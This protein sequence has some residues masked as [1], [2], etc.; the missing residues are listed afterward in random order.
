[1]VLIQASPACKTKG[2]V[3]RYL[4]PFSA[5]LLKTLS[6]PPDFSL[7]P[8]GR[9]TI[10]H[11]YP[12]NRIFEKSREM[13]IF[14]MKKIISLS[15]MLLICFLSFAKNNSNLLLDSKLPNKPLPGSL[16]EIYKKM[17]PEILKNKDDEKK[18]QEHLTESASDIR[19]YLK[20]KYG[21]DLNDLDD[22]GVL[23]T[24][25]AVIPFEERDLAPKEPIDGQPKG[26]MDPGQAFGCFMEAVGT[27]AG[28]SALVKNFVNL[29]NSGAT[30]STVIGLA[31]SIIG[32]ACAWFAVGWA[33]LKFGE[34][35]G[36]W[37]QVPDNSG[38][39]DPNPIINHTLPKEII[40]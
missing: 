6:I 35:V 8:F 34:C 25:L 30:I 24:G 38:N 28:I 9:I 18:I 23:L 19:A 27:I 17:N 15:I 16:C 33:V 29:W 14:K 31:K 10:C 13:K 37:Y 22:Q 1:M 5:S 20:E 7:I 12:E 2:K 3:Y 26:S 21:E 4:F 40:E 11:G 39:S 32:K 36:W